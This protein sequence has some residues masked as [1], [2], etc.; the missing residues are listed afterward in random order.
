MVLWLWGFETHLPHF[1]KPGLTINLLSCK[2]SSLARSLEK[3]WMGS[4]LPVRC[5]CCFG[6]KLQKRSFSQKTL[7]LRLQPQR[8]LGACGRF[9]QSPSLPQTQR[10]G[11]RLKK[12]R[13]GSTGSGNSKTPSTSVIWATQVKN[14]FET[15]MHL[16]ALVEKWNPHFLSLLEW[17]IETVY[18]SCTWHCVK[19]NWEIQ[20]VES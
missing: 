18:R 3:L 6:R 17:L 1:P 7:L 14:V 16:Q 11:K 5:L 13:H 9:D 4:T 12:V 19:H 2:V 15:L 10:W 8:M 20:W